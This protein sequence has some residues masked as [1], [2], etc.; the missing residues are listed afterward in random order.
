MLGQGPRPQDA[1]S[2]MVKRIL[3]MLALGGLLIVAGMSVVGA[4]HYRQYRH[5]ERFRAAIEE[6]NG[7]AAERDRFKEAVRGRL[8]AGDFDGLDALA[9]DLRASRETFPNGSWKLS[10][11]Y[12]G[13]AGPAE[14]WTDHEWTE[15]L[16]QAKRWRSERPESV[17]ARLVSADLWMSYA[18][19]ARGDGWS[20]EV[21]PEQWAIFQERNNEAT[22]VMSGAHGV[23]ERCPRRATTMLRIAL[24]GG[25]SKDDEAGI[26]EQAIRDDPDYQPTYTNHLRYLQPRWQGA[27]GELE[28]EVARIV[29]MPGGPERIARALWF[30]NDSNSFDTSIAP[31]PVVKQGFADMRARHPESFE[32]KSASCLFASYYKDRGE[33]KRLLAEIG[34]R[35]EPAVWRDRERFVWAYHWATWEE[36]EQAGGD[37]LARFFSWVMGS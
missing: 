17:A 21:S 24:T 35:M 37:P 6:V 15:A 20:Q 14:S 5:K 33:T 10:V 27:P 36:G 19:V 9:R 32:V 11:F 23:T 25:V 18:W 16:E 31:W 8:L 28:R 26:Y 22:A 2:R 29:R 12:Q 4:M 30:F 7:E 3:I 34:N 13:L 1:T